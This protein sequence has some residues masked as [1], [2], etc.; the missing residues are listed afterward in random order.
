MTAQNQKNLNL[1]THLS[2]FGGYVFP[3][4]SIIIPFIIRE[5][6]KEESKQMD[7]LTKEVVNFNLSYL[8]YTF[9]LKVSIIPFFFGSFFNNF[10]NVTRFDNMNFHFNGNSNYFFGFVS[11]ASVL[12]I[13]AI[14]KGILIIQ[15]AV[16]SNNNEDF[17][18]P[19]VIQFVK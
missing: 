15:A 10:R 4:G 13:L 19:F 18:Y 3:F 16:K 2:G 5:T 12:S 8:L 6:K 14:I 9:V 11:I 7:E 1:I 17:K